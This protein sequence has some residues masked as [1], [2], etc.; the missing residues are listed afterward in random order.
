MS[1]PTPLTKYLV[2]AALWALV[3]AYLLFAGKVSHAPD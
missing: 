3:A 1:W 2:G